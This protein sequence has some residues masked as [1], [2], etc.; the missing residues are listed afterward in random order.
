MSVVF[1]LKKKG[2]RLSRIVYVQVISY[3]TIIW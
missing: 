2:F 3:T 1:N